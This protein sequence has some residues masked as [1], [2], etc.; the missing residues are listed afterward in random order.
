MQ[1]TV[2][3]VLKLAAEAQADP[4]TIRKIYSSGVTKLVV[5][6]RVIDAAKRLKLPLPPP[7]VTS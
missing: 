7:V 5:Y 3:Q 1:L 2:A 6:E 4:R